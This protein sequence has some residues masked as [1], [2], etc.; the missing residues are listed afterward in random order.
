MPDGAKSMVK[1]EVEQSR[2]VVITIPE[3]VKETSIVVRYTFYPLSE[4]D[5]K[6]NAIR[7]VVEKVCYEQIFRIL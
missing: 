1:T 2:E 4:L 3:H 5:Q 6:R 7:E